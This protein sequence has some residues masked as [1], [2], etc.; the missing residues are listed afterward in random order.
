VGEAAE[1]ALLLR[2]LKDPIGLAADGTAFY[3]TVPGAVPAPY[4]RDVVALAREGGER[5]VLARAEVNPIH[6]Q[7]DGR[8]LYWISWENRATG[9]GPPVS[10]W[11]RMAPAAG[12]PVRTLLGADVAPW[13]LALDGAY[14]Y[15]TVPTGVVRV[16][17][18]G[19]PDAGA[20]GGTGPVAPQPVVTGLEQQ[21]RAEVAVDGRRVYWIADGEVRAA[22]LP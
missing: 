21:Q 15:T 18:P 14:L 17:R 22:P 8:Y 4:Q 11:V 9:E 10:S 19:G 1:P 5:R 3:T 7:S 2:D 13:G 6:L 16:P 20:D 12:G